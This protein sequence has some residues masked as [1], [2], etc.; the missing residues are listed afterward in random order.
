MEDGNSSNRISSTPEQH[1]VRSSITVQFQFGLNFDGRRYD[2]CP[3]QAFQRAETIFGKFL[4]QPDEKRDETIQEVHQQ[5]SFCKPEPESAID[6]DQS[7]SSCPDNS[8]MDSNIIAR[9][10]LP[11]GLEKE[12]VKGVD[13]QGNFSVAQPSG[14][15]AASSTTVLTAI[16]SAAGT[17]PAVLMATETSR[18]KDSYEDEELE[19]AENPG[20][21][22]NSLSHFHIEFTP[23]RLI[24]LLAKT[25]DGPELIELA[26]KGIP[27]V[28]ANLP[29]F[30]LDEHVP[31]EIRAKYGIPLPSA[32]TE[33][34]T[35]LR[36]YL[37]NAP[38]F[39]ESLEGA[40]YT[41]ALMATIV[42]AE[43]F[44]QMSGDFVSVK[45]WR[46]GHVKKSYI[47]L[48]MDPRITN[49]TTQ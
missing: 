2:C 33:D 1:P 49:M 39:L 30:R 9:W 5:Q 21:K 16:P 25:I 31:P 36:T 24:C 12:D 20:E 42:C 8:S 23:N 17:S 22:E 47:Y 13:V 34:G 10:P 45:T 27:F 14:S 38:P 6:I 19:D 3:V 29:P 26:S 37:A 40:Q 44:A 35:W 41:V 11:S 48:L 46:D 28:A 43:I 32:S 18:R 7:A 4:E 15:H